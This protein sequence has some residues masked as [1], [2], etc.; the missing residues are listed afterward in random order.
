MIPLTDS[1]CGKVLWINKKC[2]CH[3]LP[4]AFQQQGKSEEDKFQLKAVE[5]YLVNYTATNDVPCKEMCHELYVWSTVDPMPEVE[6]K[7]GSR[8]D[9]F[10]FVQLP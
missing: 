4:N 6:N 5:L 3:R 10:I 7:R 2:H 8:K 9:D 1:A